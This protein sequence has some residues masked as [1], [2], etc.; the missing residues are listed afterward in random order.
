MQAFMESLS[1][2]KKIGQGGFGS[3]YLAEADDGCNYA[4]KSIPKSK[5]QSHNI[6]REVKAGQ[7]LQ[8]KNIT[9]FICH[10]EDDQ[11]DYLVYDFIR[12]NSIVKKQKLIYRLRYVLLLRETQLQ[13]IQRDRGQEH[14]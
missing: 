5:Q 11:N 8:H 10:F 2:K 7:T 1:I 12:G 13:A 6:A 4:V 3:I 14:L 9:N